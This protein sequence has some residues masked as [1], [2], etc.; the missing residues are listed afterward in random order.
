MVYRI[1]SAP[2]RLVGRTL[3][4]P[5]AATF[6]ALF[7][8]TVFAQQP[9]AAPA[10]PPAAAPAPARPPAIPAA[11]K[12]PAATPA[13]PGQAAP[14]PAASGQSQIPE[15]KLPPLIF[16]QWIKFCPE[17]PGAKVCFTGI[18]ARLEDGRP[19]IGV[20]LID[21]ADAA[22]KKLMQITLPLGMVLAHGTRL[23]ID[24]GTPLTAPFGT[25]MA[26]GCIS[27]YDVTPDT[28]AKLKKGKTISV[29]AIA[30]FGAMTIPVA[31]AEFAKAYDGPPSDPKILEERAKKLEE[32]LK[33]KGEEL[34]KKADEARQKLEGQNPAPA[35]P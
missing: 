3:A 11:P 23:I 8:S 30:T 33:R 10:K 12:T 29:Q 31:L 35:K 15:A 13:K 7:A 19:I 4:V 24:D 17:D 14:A 21:P 5:T 27:I 25:C 1:V 2:A 22:A 28:L 9:P 6:F 32:E 16:S 34:Q 26:N 18:D 20:V